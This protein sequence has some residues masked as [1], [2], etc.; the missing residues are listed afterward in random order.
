MV[1][2]LVTIAT[3]FSFSVVAAVKPEELPA[4]GPIM[5]F[6]TILSEIFE[7]VTEIFGVTQSLEANVSTLQT[8]MD[9]NF[10]EFDSALGVLQSD[11]DIFRA[12]VENNFTNVAKIVRRSDR[13][14]I[15]AGDDT[16][17]LHVVSSEPFKLT[18]SIGGTLLDNDEKFNVWYAVGGAP[19]LANVYYLNKTDNYKIRTYEFVCKQFALYAVEP[20]DGMSIDYSYIITYSG[21]EPEIIL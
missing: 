20:G 2:V 10:T 19:I 4:D 11:L 6:S 15:S 7:I 16:F 13:L 8:S 17:Q 21:E 9:A 5:D 3:I 12:D 18:I 1:I 14:D